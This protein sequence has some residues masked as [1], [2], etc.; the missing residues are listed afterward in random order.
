MSKYNWDEY[1]Y[2]YE[3]AVEELKIK[4]KSVR[5]ELRTKGHHSPI[6]FVTGRVK[7]ISSIIQKAERLGATVR[8]LESKIDDI[9][10]IRIMCQ[11]IGDI[12]DVV[13]LIK[14]RS[15]M[16]VYYEKDYIENPKE[17]GYKS[18][19]IIIKYPMNMV[20]KVVEPL[21]EIQVRTL[22]MNFWATIEHSLNYKYQ[23]S[24]PHKLQ[25]RLKS[26]ADVASKLDNEMSQIRHEIIN[27]QT[28]FTQKSGLVDDII[29][30]INFF[31]NSDNKEIE[32]NYNKKLLEILKYDDINTIDNLSKLL[33]SI[34]YEIEKTI[35]IN[36]V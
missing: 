13:E 35:S 17:T 22:A 25:E 19:H 20:D 11:F 12:Y 31:K 24:L 2:V 3:K 18:Y 26:T 34:N 15:D 30:G 4:F 29:A 33:K 21:V 9:A 10:G 1:L 7:K 27:A 5:S 36:K 28:N 14:S 32:D 16:I 23:K 8:D 6:E